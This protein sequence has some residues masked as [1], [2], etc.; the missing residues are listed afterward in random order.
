MSCASRPHDSVLARINRCQ[1]LKTAVTSYLSN[2]WN[3]SAA[4]LAMHYGAQ[5]VSTGSGFFW[6][7]GP[8]TFLVTNWHNLAG[9]N[10]FTEQPLSK[11][12]AI[13]DRIVFR[14]FK[15]VS[16]ANS[17]GFFESVHV[18]VEVLLCSGDHSDAKWLEH[19][20]LGR[21]V[22][23][24]A[25]DVTDKVAGLQVVAANR[26]E[27]DAILDPYASQDVFVLGFPFGLIANAP[28]P[29][30]KRGTIALDPT[31]NPE[32]LPKMLIDTATREGMSGS[33]VI[34]RHIL[35]GRSYPKKDG[36]SSEPM[37]Y[38]V[39][40]LVVGIY[41]GRHYPN[42]EKA[43]LGIVWKRSAIEETVTGGKVAEA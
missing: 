26:L 24:A 43:Q 19:P 16:E 31:F 41:S 37:L 14:A 42:H 13:P 34:A 29:I 40:D 7:E 25:I 2:P 39:K 22:D 10:P 20:T 15:Q 1:G 35:V 38:T 32:A 27:S 17:E 11:T 3:H 4:Y 21:R 30:W 28:V 36:T 8:R 18:P 6:M 33:L 12:A 9:R 5:Q 23:V